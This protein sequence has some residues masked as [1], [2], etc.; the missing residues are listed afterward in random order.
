MRRGGQDY[1]YQSDDL[2]SAVALS[3]TTGVVL[4]QYAYSD[5]GYP[6]RVRSGGQA[7]SA[8]GNPYLFTGREFES[9]LGFA[10]YRTRY[11]D[12]LGGR[13]VGRDSIGLWGDS[14]NLGN[15]Y[16]YSRSAPVNFT[17]PHGEFVPIL[18][19]A[20]AV[21]EFGLAIYDGY[22]TVNTILDPCAT[23]GEKWFAGGLWALGALLPG[24]GYS[25]ID[26]AAKHLDDAGDVAKG[27]HRNLPELPEWATTKYRDRK[28]HFER[29]ARED[30][31]RNL[32]ESREELQW[33]KQNGDGTFTAGPKKSSEELF[34]LHK[35]RAHAANAEYIRT[36]GYR[37]TGL[38]DLSSPDKGL[39]GLR[40]EWLELEKE[41]ASRGWRI[42]R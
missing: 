42:G 1:F 13:F 23:T 40:G 32:R 35:R 30:W 11:Y 28:A 10:F 9:D 39:R 18:L 2:H 41:W 25:K 4:E 27:W 31:E 19:G 24:G 29:Q 38:D 20:W 16:S 17:D 21:I 7:S 8:L 36:G 26:D 34:E 37:V 33:W 3:S 12:P 15:P 5:H 6:T 22:D 14:Y